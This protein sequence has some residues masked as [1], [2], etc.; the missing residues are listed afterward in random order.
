MERRWP[1]DAKMQQFADLASR[2][3]VT[4]GLSRLHRY[5][6]GNCLIT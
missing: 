5:V 6:C 3:I 1:C 4:L 2:Q